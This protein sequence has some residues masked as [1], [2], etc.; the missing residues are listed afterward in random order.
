LAALYIVPMMLG[1]VVLGPVQIAFLAVACSYLRSLFDTSGSPAELT[2]R[3]VFAV[4]AYAVSGLFVSGW[5]RNHELVRN[6]LIRMQAEQN[7]RREAEEQLKVM[8]ESSPA[9][10][11]TIDGDGTVLAANAAANSLFMIPSGQSVQG[12]KI[13]H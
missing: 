3:F 6:H 5:V 8:A 13:R 7:R 10:I 11:L 12:R 1:A 2:L 4:V 9:A